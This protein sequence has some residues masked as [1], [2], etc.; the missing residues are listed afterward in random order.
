MLVFCICRAVLP[1]WW[2]RNNSACVHA[3]PFAS[4]Q[5][6]TAAPT[7]ICRLL[8]RYELQRQLVFQ[9]KQSALPARSCSRISLKSF[10]RITACWQWSYSKPTHSQQHAISLHSSG[11][12]ESRPCFWCLLGYPLCVHTWLNQAQAGDLCM[13]LSTEKP[14][15][16]PHTLQ[17]VV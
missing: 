15:I 3:D 16:D 7:L 11:K 17:R 2:Y 6:Q 10:T 5:L 4:S 13:H 14:W 8:L 1:C 12:S 9:A